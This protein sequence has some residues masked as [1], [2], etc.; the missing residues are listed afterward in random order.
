VAQTDPAERSAL[1]AELAKV[2]EII[3]DPD[4]RKALAGDTERTLETAGVNLSVIPGEV[5]DTLAGMSFE[6]L[7]LLSRIGESLAG[8][9]LAMG[10]FPKGMRVWFF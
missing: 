9:G 3:G 6:E 8:A 7:G 10:E 5:V 4:Q 1:V 2:A